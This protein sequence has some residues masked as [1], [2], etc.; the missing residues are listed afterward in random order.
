MLDKI[1]NNYK[2][3][4]KIFD[5]GIVY[6]KKTSKKNDFHNNTKVAFINL[7]KKIMNQASGRF[8]LV[9]CKYFETAGFD[10]VLKTA[11]SYYIVLHKLKTILLDQNYAFVKR[12]DSSL[13]TISITNSSLKKIIRLHYELPEKLPQ[14]DYVAPFP[15]H[16]VQVLAYKN[17]VQKNLRNAR[18]TIH[19]FF[20]GTNE[21]GEY[22]GKKLNQKFNVISRFDVISFIKNKL[23]KHIPVK[24]ISDQQEL[25]TL[26]QTE[27]KDRGIVI[28]EVKTADADWLTFLSQSNFFIAPPGVRYPWCHNSVEAMSVGAIPIL[29]YSNLFYPH[30]EHKKNCLTYTNFKELEEAIELA[31]AMKED[32]IAVMRQN[33]IDYFE[34]YLSPDA[35]AKKI[36]DFAESAKT[37][38][39][40]AVPFIV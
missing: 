27:T 15:M 4:Y 22:S 34:A 26:L 14:V 6:L 17:V 28:S 33:V 21:K 8:P 11:P 23:G 1:R 16:P 29:Q 25:Y 12:M 35:L 20:S 13:D 19:M 24:A 30:L 40:V 10:I 31:Y 7:D 37:E 5:S 32:E 2:L 18:R 38:I 9:L 3:I 36:N 39:D